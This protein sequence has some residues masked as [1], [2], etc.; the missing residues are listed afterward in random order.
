MTITDRNFNDTIE[1]CGMED[2][3]FSNALALAYP[4]MGED[5]V[6]CNGG[7]PNA[8]YNDLAC[9]QED[10]LKDVC[11]TEG[12]SGIYFKSSKHYL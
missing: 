9:C 7:R 11:S 4:R 2:C 10:E 6:V 3:L 8:D 12:S 5:K 1:T